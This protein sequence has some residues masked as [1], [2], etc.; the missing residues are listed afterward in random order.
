MG[1]V[2]TSVPAVCPQ[3]QALQTVGSQAPSLVAA[4]T[5]VHRVTHPSLQLPLATIAPGA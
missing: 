3:V 2:A 5:Q 1:K 4:W